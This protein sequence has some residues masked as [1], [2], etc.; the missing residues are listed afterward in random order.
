MGRLMGGAIIIETM[1][2][3]PGVGQLL[4]ESIYQQEYLV[5]QG[6][7]LFVAVAFILINLLTDLVYAVVDPRFLRDAG[8]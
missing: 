3:L 8:H 6:I 2:A 1:F 5:T 4:V 7:V